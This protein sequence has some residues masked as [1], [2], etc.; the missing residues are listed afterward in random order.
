MT[1]KEAG[2]PDLSVVVPAYDEEEALPL[3]HRRLSRALADTRLRCE[4]VFVDDGSRDRTAAVLRS[5]QAEDPAVCVVTLSRNF[6]HQAALTAG[7]ELSRG[8]AVVTMDADLQHPPELIASMLERWRAGAAVVNGVRADERRAGWL[9][10]GASRL[11]YRFLNLISDTPVVA[12]APDF[13]LLDRR[14]VD[15]LISMRE[16]HRFLR[17]M[18]AWLG[19]P[20]ASVP[21]DPPERARGR[22]KYTWGRMTRLAL[23]G[24]ASG[25]IRPLR[26]ALWLGAG[27]L[28]ASV[29][30]ALYV[31]LIFALHRTLI[32]GW[33]S[34]V[35][36]VMFM[37]GGQLILLGIIG[38]YVGRTYEQVKGRP[39]YVIRE[40]RRGR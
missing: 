9:K 32:K 18:V 22:T 21:F 38:E 2:G 3:F 20:E 10:G 36:L 11:F 35:L 26:A 16:S 40:V 31:L 5:L 1:E 27:V 24:I 17:G 29:A 33:A 6:G 19:F 7:L 14:V 37:G 13:R 15:A 25:S 4:I 12:G 34:I 23:D 8:R 28:A 30:Y 39:L